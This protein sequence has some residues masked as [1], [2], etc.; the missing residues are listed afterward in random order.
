MFR[1]LKNSRRLLRVCAQIL[2]TA[3]VPLCASSFALYDEECGVQYFEKKVLYNWSATHSCKPARIYEPA[4]AQECTRLLQTCHKRKTKVRIVGAS[5]SPNGIGFSSSSDDCLISVAALNKVHVDVDARTVTVGAGAVVQDVLNELQK[6]DLTLENF[7]SIQEQQMGGWTQVSAHG[8]GTSLPPVDEMILHLQIA[9]PTEGILN[10]S[11][12]DTEY[13]HSRSNSIHSDVNNQLFHLCKVGLGSLGLV[14]EMTLKCVPRFNL[15]EHTMVTTR[16]KITDED[17]KDHAQR[18]QQFRHVRYMWIPYTDTVV[19]V[20]SNKVQPQ[21]DLLNTKKF[22]K[23]ENMISSFPTEAL[24]DLLLAK[25]T[26]WRASE[27]KDLTFSQCRDELLGIAPLNLEHVKAVNRAEAQF[28]E[29]SSG[30]RIGDSTEILGFDCGGQQL[31]FEVCLPIGTLEN[32]VGP[33]G[34]KD[35]AFVR[36]MLDILEAQGIPAPSPI[37]QRWTARSLSPMSPAYSS[38]PADVFSWVGIIMYLPPALSP[39]QRNEVVSAFELYTNALAPLCEEYGAVP[40]WAKIELPLAT[41]LDQS[42]PV[43]PVPMPAVESH[44]DS[45]TSEMKVTYIDAISGRVSSRSH[46][47]K[48]A[49]GDTRVAQYAASASVQSLKQRLQKRYNTDLFNA[50]RRVLDPENILSNHIVDTLLP[51]HEGAQNPPP[52]WKRRTAS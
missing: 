2:T 4:T 39:A 30:V 38:N 8:T 35:I 49:Q 9:T 6:H 20:V 33:G 25:N 14:T 1:N 41:T 37:E 19:N 5:L 44:P 31:V 13:L 42:A 43:L 40:H 51:L 22:E 45:A 23:G 7:S 50:Y 32:Q 11:A 29:K 15:E 36:K 28:W 17:N 21:Q 3:A 18:L 16:N 27:V 47:P 24:C 52:A 48:A 10:L 34:G 12:S 26:N 46:S